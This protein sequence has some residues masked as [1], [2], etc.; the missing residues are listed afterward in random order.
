MPRM[1]VLI[2][3]PDSPVPVAAKARVRKPATALSSS[4]F[5]AKTP[6]L[7]SAFAIALMTSGFGKL[8]IRS[9]FI[10][11]FLPLLHT[12]DGRVVEVGVVK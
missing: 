5:V 8:R 3:N 9:I 12:P 10:L 6:V 11:N 1:H 2:E 4:V 7:S